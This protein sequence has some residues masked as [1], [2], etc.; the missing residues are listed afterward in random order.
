[1]LRT[2]YRNRHHVVLAHSLSP[3]RATLPAAT[4]FTTIAA[5]VCFSSWNLHVFPKVAVLLLAVDR[6]A[7][8]QCLE[9]GRAPPAPVGCWLK[10]K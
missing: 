3:G 10:R 7:C 2:R 9:S 1:M 8:C 4:I 5:S 6:L